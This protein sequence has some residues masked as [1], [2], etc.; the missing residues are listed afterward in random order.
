MQYRC[1]PAVKYRPIIHAQYKWTACS[2]IS[3]FLLIS[4]L[5]HNNCANFGHS[6]SV[7]YLLPVSYFCSLRTLS[8]FTQ[9][10]GFPK[11]MQKR[12]FYGSS[13]KLQAPPPP[14]FNTNI[15]QHNVTVHF[16]SRPHPNSNNVT[17]PVSAV[18]EC[19][20][21]CQ[22]LQPVNKSWNPS[23]LSYQALWTTDSSQFLSL[24]PAALQSVATLSIT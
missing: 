22:L 17:K 9:A 3:E 15:P 2:P 1:P 14:K 24:L 19:Y 18:P 23:Q 8:H 20:D 10:V 6:H 13:Y 12:N 7:R 11:T 5:C 16:P 4:S 21:K